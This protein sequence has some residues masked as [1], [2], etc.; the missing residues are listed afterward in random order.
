MSLQD[1]DKQGK[2]ERLQSVFTDYASYRSV[3]IMIPPLM[4]MKRNVKIF[5]YILH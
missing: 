3:K 5:M 1:L 4:I 2:T